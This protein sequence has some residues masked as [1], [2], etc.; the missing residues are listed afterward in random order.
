MSSASHGEYLAL[1]RDK[2]RLDLIECRRNLD[3]LQK[4]FDKEIVERF[5]R[6]VHNLKGA[7]N[8]MGFKSMAHV[9]H[10]LEELLTPFLEGKMPTTM[11]WKKI[12]EK[13][14]DL[15]IF[16][17][18][19]KS[20]LKKEGA[21]TSLKVLFEWLKH[22]S[23]KQF[24][25]IQ[26]DIE[27]SEI[28]MEEENW[29]Q[30]NIILT[31][32]ISNAIDH[33]LQG[34]GVVVLKARQQKNQIELMVENGGSINWEN[35]IQVA[36]DKK[37]ISSEEASQYRA[38]LAQPLSQDHTMQFLEMLCIPGLTSSET[39]QLTS[40]RG[41]GLAIVRELLRKMG[42]EMH[43]ECFPEKTRFR[44]MLPLSIAKRK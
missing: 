20:Q 4:V 37:K 16:H 39:V 36:V 31:Q 5:F 6:C 27:D 11:E 12:E 21:S 38:Q 1:F 2:V 28:E 22:S 8:F 30:I 33:G 42:G 29:H 34:K 18:E 26:V 10:D 17:E 13:L 23:E 19:Q 9:A 40:G 32:L 44:V 25:E 43:L 35:M 24:P 15:E 7:A 14:L 3:Q 41:R